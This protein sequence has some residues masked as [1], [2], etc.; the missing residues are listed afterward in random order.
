M[1]PF[2]SE[3]DN[4]TDARQCPLMTL[5]RHATTALVSCC[6]RFRKRIRDVVC[7]GSL[8]FQSI[9]KVPTIFASFRASKKCRCSSYQ[10][11]GK[12]GGRYFSPHLC[13]FLQAHPY[14]RWPNNPQINNQLS[15]RPQVQLSTEQPL[16][17][18]LLR[19]S[20]RP[21]FARSKVTIQARCTVIIGGTTTVTCA[22]SR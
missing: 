11:R 2:E 6:Q 8:R 17:R 3:A 15:V 16:Q 4:R 7:A 19:V 18:L 14:P 10:P 5:M 22:I 9:L 1:S 20:S 13:Q 12:S 21:P